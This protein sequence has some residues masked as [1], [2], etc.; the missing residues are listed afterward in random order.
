[1][2]AGV[3]LCAG[4]SRRFG[5]DQHKLL[6]TFRGKP[7]VS[8]ALEHAAEAHLDELIIVMGPVDVTEF[9]PEGAIAVENPDWTLGQAISL[10]AGIEAVKARGHEVAVVGLGDQPLVP[11]ETWSAVA[12]AD[13]PIAVATYQGH[14]GPPTRLSRSVWPLLPRDGDEGA[15]LLMQARPDLVQEVPSDGYAFDVDTV[16]D[17]ARWG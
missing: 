15:R 2:T 9:L 16:E 6:A 12:A 3:V 10:Q 17:L 13:S 14:R 1:M 11:P 8:W 7:L 4:G 5:Q